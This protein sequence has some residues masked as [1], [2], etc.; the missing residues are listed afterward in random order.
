M[1][2]CCDR[3]FSSLCLGDRSLPAIA[4]VEITIDLIQGSLPLPVFF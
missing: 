3:T 4:S 1:S 2:S